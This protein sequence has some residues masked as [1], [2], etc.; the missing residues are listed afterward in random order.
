MSALKEAVMVNIQS[1]TRTVLDFPEIGIVRFHGNNSNGKSVFVKVLGDIVSNNISRPSVRRSIIRRGNNACDLLLTRYDGVSLHTHIA[2]EAADTFAELIRADGTSVRRYLRDKAIPSLVREFGWHYD[3]DT[4]ISLNI[5]Q[6]IDGF[7][8]VDTNKRVNFDLL[9]YIR[10]DQ[11]AEAVV[12]N[13]D[14]LLKET[15][16]QRAACYHSFEVNQAAY[17]SLQYWDIAE[18]TKIAER[19]K[20]LSRNMNALSIPPMPEV[21][22]VPNVKLHR[23]LS[24]PMPEL[25]LCSQNPIFSEKFPEVGPH[26]QEIVSLAS[27]VC[28]TC[29]RRL[30]DNDEVPL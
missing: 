16:K 2:L 12:E 15:K 28:P 5:H 4:R 7:L 13:M 18:E 29:K 17:T 30:F 3:E 11:Y 10:T 1:H 20:Y 14:A 24:A 27:G 22:F 26:L 8:F 9:N 6:D 21:H 19:C 23:T 25:R